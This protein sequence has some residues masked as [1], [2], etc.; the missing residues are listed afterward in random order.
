MDVP[1]QRL[2]MLPNQPN[3]FEPRTYEI[4]DDSSSA[5]SK[6]ILILEDDSTFADTLKQL[7]DSQGYGITIV[8]TGAEGLQKIL[9]ADFDAIVCDMVMPNFPGDM[10]YLAVQRARPH[11][12]K[13][14]IFTTGHQSDPKIAGFIKKSGCP[15][16]FK[17]FEMRDL[18]DA[19]ETVTGRSK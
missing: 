11:L 19:L 16:L 8:P 3:N 10:F 13:R 17:P 4:T 7:L 5:R 9:A 1:T 2:P 12:T 6:T 14:F 15:A 18:F